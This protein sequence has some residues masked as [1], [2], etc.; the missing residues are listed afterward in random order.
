MPTLAAHRP[1]PWYGWLVLALMAVGFAA[2]GGLVVYRSALLWRHMGDLDCYLRAA[3][4]VRVEPDR[5][6]DV[7]EDN[8]WHYNYPPLFAI[9][10]TPLADPPFAADR[11]GMPPFAV[12]V[13]VFY[14]I[15]LLTIALAVH[16]LASA[17][18][19]SSPDQ[20]VRTQPR[21]CWRWWAL[22][23][24][25]VLA[26]LAPIG[27][28][29]MR[30]QANVFLLL[31]L[32]GAMA[33]VIHNRRGLAGACLA[34]TACLKIFPAYL[35]LYPLWRRDWRAAGGWALGLFVGLLLI[36]AVVLG[37]MRTAACYQRL[38]VV[39]IGPALH[40]S[41][42]DSRAKELI[43]ATATDSQSFLVVLHN[44][45]HLD[46]DR[47]HRPPTAAAA[48]RYAHFALAGLFT[49]LTLA[50]ASRRRREDGPGVALFLG[51]LTLIMLVSSPVCH[52]HYF[53]LSLPLVMALLARM[54]D[55]AGDARLTG[56]V[57]LLLLTQLIGNALPLIPAFWVVKDAGL[58]LY[59]ALG[60]WAVACL[61]LWRGGASAPTAAADSDGLAK[62]A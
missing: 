33:A 53:M 1:P 38:A 58:A 56:G 46:H 39:L 13:A 11:T 19:R 16:I 24:L 40:L 12:S 9:L 55:R 18:E 22:R 50:A 5:I 4:A 15:S 37:P 29:L 27:H 59:T 7:M 61:S 44:T 43:E 52:T 26:C 3:W 57:W 10:M 54:W 62:A 6:Y 45:L 34:G 49:L 23:V 48:V 21:G 42:D 47:W 28:T 20:A 30:G 8:A 51:A 14:V 32:C 60:L 36:P 31:L 25:P 35:L 17:L 41:D 2:W